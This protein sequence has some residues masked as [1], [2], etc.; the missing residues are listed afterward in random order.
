MRVKEWE[1][2]VVFLHEVGKG[3]G[4][5]SYGIQVA[6]LAGLPEAV[7]RAGADVLHQLEAGE[8]SGKAE[9][10]VDDLPLFSAAVRREAPKMDEIIRALYDFAV[11]PCLPLQEPLRRRAHGDRRGRRLRPR[12]AGAGLRHRPAVPAALQA[13]A[14][15]R[16][17][18]RIHALH[19][20]GPRP[21]GRPRHP[22]HR[23][24]HAALAHA[25][26]TSAPRSSRRAIL[27]RQSRCSTSW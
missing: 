22:Q 10:L 13:D 18:R 9:R 25:D 7:V 15:G 8:T 21:E 16:A 14:L 12:H 20:V 6:R 11:T 2:E 17:G 26:I 4:D 24:M 23:R 19:A 3:A 27:G 5:R 1:G